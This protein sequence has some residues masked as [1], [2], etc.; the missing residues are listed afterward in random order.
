[1]FNI[2][3]S[4]P[5]NIPKLLTEQTISGQSFL[6]R[7]FQEALGCE[8]RDI[9]RIELTYFAAT[10][11]TY[12]YLRFGKQSNREDVLDAYTLNVFAESIPSCGE[13]IN[14]ADIIEEYQRRYAEYWNLIQLVFE[15]SKSS[16][17]NPAATL[18][19][20]AYSCVT[21]S[22]P[23]D[24]MINIVSAAGSIQEFFLTE[25]EFV[26]KEL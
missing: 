17:G 26:K 15:P 16:S 13:N 1:M 18:L 22:S 23:K 7:L 19:M 4:K 2:F 21:G 14:F 25:I 24:R 5:A 12:V 11:T 6:Y 10:I 3:K 8:K 20:H 9:R